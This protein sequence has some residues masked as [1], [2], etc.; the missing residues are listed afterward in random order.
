MKTSIK[1]ALIAMVMMAGLNLMANPTPPT[2]RLVFKTIDAS[3]FIMYINTYG[4]A[5]KVIFKD[6]DGVFLGS[7]RIKK[8]KRYKKTYDLSYVPEDMYYVKLI[9][10]KS[11]KVYTFQDGKI[12]LII[13][14]QNDDLLKRKAQLTAL[15]L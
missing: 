14:T 1:R 2:N 9:D 11:T 7:D 13:A 5:V 8:G 4:S 10:D 12:N 15:L 6:K 3:T